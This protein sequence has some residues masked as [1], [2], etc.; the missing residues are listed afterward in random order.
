[1]HYTSGRQGQREGGFTLLELL[2]VVAIL[3][4]LMAGMVSMFG[5]IGGRMLNDDTEKRVHM[6]GCRL[7]VEVRL[8]GRVP[9]ALIDIEPKISVARWV[10]G[11][12]F[13]DAWENP[14]QYEPMGNRFRVWSMGADGISGNSDDI[15]FGDK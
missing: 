11:G 10:K 3:L 5:W 13:I 9:P 4:I 15:E 12:E 1:M 8:E 2:M 14:L 7:V 6:I